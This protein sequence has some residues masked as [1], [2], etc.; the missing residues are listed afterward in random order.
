MFDS[1]APRYDLLNRLLS[2]RRDLY[3]RR[4]AVAELLLR[5]GG[6]Y[7][8]VATGTGDVALEILRQNPTAKVVGIDFAS[9]MLDL[10]KRKVR[11]ESINLITGDAQALPFPDATFD[12]SIIAYGIRNVADQPKALGEMVRVVR[13]NGR[14]VVLEFSMPSGLLGKVYGFYFKRVLPWIGGVV[15]RNREAYHYLHNSVEAF[16]SCHTFCD[17]MVRA[18]LVSVRYYPLTFGTTICY[19]AEKGAEDGL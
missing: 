14:V 2:A 7:L 19:V 8:D 11:G 18:G 17:M 16:P 1:I 13:P 10:A 9:S 4:F 12:G 3:W 15:S 6:R 5:P